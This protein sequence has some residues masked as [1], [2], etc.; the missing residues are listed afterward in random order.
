[1]LKRLQ[2]I[3]IIVLI[4]TSTNACVTVVDAVTDNPIQ[5]NPN[6]RSLGTYIDDKQLNTIARVNIKKAHPLLSDSNV[7]VHSFN[8][9]VLLTGEVPTVKLREL[10]GNTVRD[11][12][13]VREVYN[14]LVVGPQRGFFAQR[15]DSTLG[16]KI[17]S[18]L[19]IYKDIKSR[20]VEVIVEDHTVFLMGLLSKAQAEKITK[21]VSETRGVKKVVRTIEY[22]D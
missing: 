12:D 2:L 6:K 1:M 9:V 17:K 14:E 21:V 7:N 8:A 18:K 10:A 3:T 22:I 5:P 15:L 11:I 19:L 4:V 13:R 20:R 16:T